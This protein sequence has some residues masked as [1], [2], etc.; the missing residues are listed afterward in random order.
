LLG[1]GYAWVGV[2]VQKVGVEELKRRDPSRYGVLEHPGDGYTYDIFTR[3]GRIVADPASPVLGGLHPR[4]VLASGASQSATGLLTYVNAVHPLVGVDDGFQLQS[5]VG[6]ALPL[7]EGASM[8]A[9]PIVRTDVDVPVLDVQSETDIIV[10]G[11]HRNRQEDHAN[12]RLWEVAGSGHAAEYGRSLT[13]PPNPTA[14]GDPCTARINSAPTFAVGKAARAA[15]A[16]W[17]TTGV[18][19]PSAPRVGLADPAA[20]DPVAR[21]QY[22]NALGG[23]RYP[24]V[25]VPIARVDGLQNS[26]PPE[27][28]GQVFFCVLAGRTLPLSDT[29]LAEMY[30]TSA[31]YLARFNAAMDRAV[32]ARFLLPE[33]AQLLKATAA[34]SPPVA[35]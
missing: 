16:R 14:P 12:F 23:I 15:L 13:W 7:P 24:H 2:S 5:H 30:P 8:P 6:V 22:G 19:P 28:P 31:T 25:E 4:V 26:A 11:T 10:F 3:A 35:P 34:A 18:A 20:P 33:D 9:H 27:D 17:S 29:Q 1:A 32:R 21:D